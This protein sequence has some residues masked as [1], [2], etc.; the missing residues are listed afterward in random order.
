MEAELFDQAFQELDA[1]NAVAAGIQSR[2]PHGDTHQVGHHRDDNPGDG[3]LCGD[4]DRERELAG[5][6]VHAAGVHHR[7]A[8][9]HRLL[10]KYTLSRQRADAAVRKRRTQRGHRRRIDFDRTGRKIVV[11]CRRKIRVLGERAALAHVVGEREVAIRR[12]PLGMEHRV[13]ETRCG[14]ARQGSKDIAQV[15]EPVRSRQVAPDQAA[16]HDRAGVDHRV[17]R[18]AV[19]VQRQLV[20]RQPAR[21]A[22]HVRMH[23]VLAVLLERRAIEHRLAARLQREMLAGIADIQAL[24]VDRG[25][26]HREPL[27]RYARELRDR[28]CNRTVLDRQHAV[29]DLA[30]HAGEVFEFR[31]HQLTFYRALEQRTV[32]RQQRFEAFGVEVVS[33]FVI[34]PV[35]EAGEAGIVDDDARL[36]EA[37]EDCGFADHTLAVLVE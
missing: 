11:E 4:A 13:V 16:G 10:R 27:R 28:V 7:Q 33:L 25:D 14:A 37:L 32:V 2:R 29:V 9:L 15:L 18:Q 20:E 6:V 8:V 1:A 19:L 22:A 26:R 21:L 3:R 12:L 30:D 31:D 24:A 34:E 35:E 23:L 5:I 36:F 17:V